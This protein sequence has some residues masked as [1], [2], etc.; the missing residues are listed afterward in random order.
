MYMRGL[1]EAYDDIESKIKVYNSEEA[2]EERAKTKLLTGEVDDFIFESEL[3]TQ[4][5]LKLYA[6]SPD[7]VNFIYDLIIVRLSY[8]SRLLVSN[9][10]LVGISESYKCLVNEIKMHLHFATKDYN[11]MCRFG[12]LTIS[13]YVFDDGLVYLAGIVDNQL[14]FM[15]SLRDGFR[16]ARPIR[17]SSIS[18]DGVDTVIIPVCINNI[19]I[20]LSLNVNNYEISVK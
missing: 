19:W 2:R 3:G 17:A 9:D 5:G 16:N 10:R 13:H 20:D 4:R 7:G 14:V 18:F 6:E 1:K 11:T 8:I 12:N 15:F